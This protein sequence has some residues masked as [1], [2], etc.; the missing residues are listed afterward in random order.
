MRKST[1]SGI[2]ALLFAGLLT[3][4]AGIGSSWFTNG[5]IKTWFN[6]WG[7][8][9]QEIVQ[10]NI[11]DNPDNPNNSDNSDKDNP[12]LPNVDGKTAESL[13]QV[14]PIVTSNK[15][16]RMTA[17]AS[18]PE[19]YGLSTQAENSVF[20]LTASIDP[21]ETTDQTVSWEMIWA[22][23]SSSWASGKSVNDYVELTIPEEGA[24]TV[25]LKAKQAFGERIRVISTANSNPDATAYCVLDYAKRVTGVNGQF[26]SDLS[27]GEDFNGKTD[28]FTYKCSSTSGFVENGGKVSSFIGLNY[29]I[30]TYNDT[31]SYSLT[32]APEV[33]FLNAVWG[34]QT[35]DYGV[36]IT[37]TDFTSPISGGKLGYGRYFL[38]TGSNN[39][40]LGFSYAV[41]AN[42]AVQYLMNNPNTAIGTVTVQA[43]GTYSNFTKTYFVYADTAS[44]TTV[45]ESL[46]LSDSSIIM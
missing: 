16:M 18:L 41:S 31:F 6:S 2:I 14:T 21:F 1:M 40:S 34:I 37:P 9:K 11:P 38:L 32:Y 8:G 25:T 30:G 23:S 27:I 20:T 15:L 19:D 33:S 4:T 29:G 3:L 26:G 44:L 35:V 5:N 42:L 28:R 13:F 17:V 43:T 7:K 22:N 45:A 12:E 24:K 46:G 36:S 10:P 39:S